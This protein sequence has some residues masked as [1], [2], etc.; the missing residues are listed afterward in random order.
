MK[1]VKVDISWVAL[2]RVAAVG[3]TARIWWVPMEL[4]AEALAGRRDDPHSTAIIHPVIVDD[5]ET[6]D[7]LARDVGHEARHLLVGWEGRRR[8]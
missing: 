5:R 4:R 1:Q 7:I 2:G 6:N 8:R 3:V